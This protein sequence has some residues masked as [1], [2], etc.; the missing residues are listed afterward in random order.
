MIR[1]III[2]A[3]ASGI[4]YFIT[5]LF[6]TPRGSWKEPLKLM[7]PLLLLVLLLLIT[8]GKGHLLGI[9]LAGLVPVLKNL[10]PY[11]L[12]LLPYLQ[13]QRSQQQS[14]QQPPHPE[15]VDHAP[16]PRRSAGPLSKEEALEILGLQAGATPDEIKMAHRR[17]MQKLH[18]DHGG[19]DYLASKLNEA[20]KRLLS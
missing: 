13:H 18:P 14:Q 3:L 19:S 4:F 11:L 15:G 9:L 12:R 8:T 7:A 20:K 2:A 16:P 5:K 17:L 10:A 1:I 6:K